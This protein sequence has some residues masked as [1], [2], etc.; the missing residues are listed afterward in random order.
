MKTNMLPL[1]QNSTSRNS[2]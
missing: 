1:C 2:V